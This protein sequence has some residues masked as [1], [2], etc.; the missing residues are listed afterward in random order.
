MVLRGVLREVT[1]FT[2][3][4]VR[5]LKPLFESTLAAWTSA[6]PA[7]VWAPVSTGP[8]DHRFLHDEL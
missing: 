5:S 7:T 4:Y 3:S 1:G 8:S 2:S 6:L